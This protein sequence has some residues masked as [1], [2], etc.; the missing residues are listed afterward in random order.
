MVYIFTKDDS[1]GSW[2][3]IH[4]LTP[5]NTRR[6]QSDHLHGNYGYSV[7]VNDECIAGKAPYDSYLGSLI[8]LNQIV[9]WWAYIN[10]AMMARTNN[11]NVLKYN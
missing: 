4:K 11:P 8:T 9:G 3:E 2:N 1:S 7:A 6:S 5:E 10:E